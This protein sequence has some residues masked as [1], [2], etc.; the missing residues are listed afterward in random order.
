M[1]SYFEQL[2]ET[3][4]RGSNGFTDF[5]PIADFMLRALSFK[6]ESLICVD[7]LEKELLSRNIIQKKILKRED[8]ISNHSFQHPELNRALY[9]ISL[10]RDP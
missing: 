1:N 2:Y 4:I 8:F 5:E 3:A 7:K 9:Y 10:I 6:T